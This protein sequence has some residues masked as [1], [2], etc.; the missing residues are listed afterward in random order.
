MKTDGGCYDSNCWRDRR[1]KLPKVLSTEPDSDK[2][3]GGWNGWTCVLDKYKVL[4]AFTRP[5]FIGRGSRAMPVDV[6]GSIAERTICEQ[7][8]RLPSV[9]L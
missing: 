5:R 2:I 6:S 9:R 3:S 8:P 7:E 4:P 1:R